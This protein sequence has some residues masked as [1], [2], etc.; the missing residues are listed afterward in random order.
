[1]PAEDV[2]VRAEQPTFQS[3]NSHD[4]DDDVWFDCNT[5]VDDDSDVTAVKCAAIS[6]LS[7]SDP[8]SSGNTN[9]SG[10]NS[11]D[12]SHLQPVFDKLCDTLT[13]EERTQ[14]INFI[15][16]NAD[17]FGTHEYDVG[18]TDLLTAR[19][20]TDPSA[21]P[22][23]EPLRRHAKVHLDV[24][25]DMVEKMKQ[26][27]IVEDA[28]SPWCANLVVVGRKDDKGNPVNPR[29]TIDFRG[30]NAVTTRDRY[31]IP[32]LGDCLKSLDRAKYMSVIDLSNSFYQVPIDLQDRDKTA[33]V[34]RQG[35]F[36]LTRLGQGCTNS[37]AVFCRL[38][39]M[40]LR[41]LICCLA[42]IDDTICFS[43]SFEQHLH[44]L[45]LVFDRFRKA[46]LKLKA[47][48]CKLFQTRCK[49]VGHY[50]SENGIEVD[51]AKIGCVLNWPFP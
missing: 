29:V 48:K 28:C 35:Q 23:A 34:T 51:S 19:I 21:N 10:N 22:V 15:K 7:T 39:A 3:A 8:G 47:T 17:V 5:A 36:R 20:I 14:A 40:V 31:P 11:E 30:L 16:G 2:S 37:P 12:F 18:C 4:D 1:M 33:F 44:D 32:H 26:A 50:V 42:Y 9:S 49:F 24:I 27:G 13:D 45:D 43:A 41:G 25:D 6:T 38:M 46:K